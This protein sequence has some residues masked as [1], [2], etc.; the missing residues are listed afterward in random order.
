MN[1]LQKGENISFYKETPRIKEV[2][3]ALG[4]KATSPDGTPFDLEVSCFLLNQNGKVI[5]DNFF[6]FANYKSSED[7]SVIYA[8]GLSGQDSADKV[9]I[10]INI[11]NVSEHIKKIAVVVTLNEAKS[12]QQN[13]GQV[14]KA[15]LRIINKRDNKE[16]ARYN[17]VDSSCKF[18]AMTVGEVYRRDN[19]WKFRA[20]GSGFEAGLKPLAESYGVMLG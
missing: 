20:L 19:E 15:Y 9:L 1:Y 3:L 18:T 10:G 7:G 14:Q 12:S 5:Q 11:A 6:I 4:W 13:L 16:L 8:E 2:I 17:F